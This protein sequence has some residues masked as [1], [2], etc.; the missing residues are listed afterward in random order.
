MTLGEA[1]GGKTLGTAPAVTLGEAGDA[2]G[3]V[4]PASP[5]PTVTPGVAGAVPPVALPPIRDRGGE[6]IADPSKFFKAIVVVLIICI[7][8]LLGCTSYLALS[9]AKAVERLA[10]VQ[11]LQVGMALVIG[12]TALT[13]GF[14]LVWYRIRAEYRIGVRGSVTGGDGRL[15][16]LS[17]S[18]GLVFLLC[19]TV[20]IIC[21]MFKPLH[22][23]SS[24]GV[25]PVDV[26]PAKVGKE[27]PPLPLE[28]PPPPMDGPPKM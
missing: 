2:A 1:G 26:D 16:M 15:A 7:L 22:L 13:L 21:A 27:Q 24:G 10:L 11:G 25:T 17:N 9:N 5:P 18:P 3:A 28:L 8:G 6:E 20:L 19:G 4:I 14:L 23:E 12:L